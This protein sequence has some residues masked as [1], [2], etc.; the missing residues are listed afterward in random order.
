MDE[1]GNVLNQ[2]TT[3]HSVNQC[4]INIPNYKINLENNEDKEF[5]NDD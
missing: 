3:S 1:K 4:I 5:I 2:K